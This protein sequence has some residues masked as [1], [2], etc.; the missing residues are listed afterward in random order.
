MTNQSC[1]GGLLEVT[2]VFKVLAKL[3]LTE[4]P[5]YVM[6]LEMIFDLPTSS[7]FALLM[8]SLKLQFWQFFSNVT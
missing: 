1:F 7:W 5:P 3:V 8:I 2:L 4:D 6:L